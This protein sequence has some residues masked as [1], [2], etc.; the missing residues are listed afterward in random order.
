METAVMYYKFI[1]VFK[2]VSGVG[3]KFPEM[4][5]FQILALA[6]AAKG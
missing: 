5:I 3:G 6:K 2:T 4:S 1:L